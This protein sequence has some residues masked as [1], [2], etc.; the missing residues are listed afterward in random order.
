[1]KAAKLNFEF[2]G[3]KGVMHK[4]ALQSK[5]LANLVKQCRDIPGK[6]LFQYLRRWMGNAV[7]LARAISITYLKEI[8][9]EDFTAKDFR[10]W[11][12]SVSA[13]YAFKEAGEFDNV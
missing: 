8:T 2:K 13:L 10:T 4:V 5:K 6:E 12:G 3:K 7:Q 1:L 11:A 9:G